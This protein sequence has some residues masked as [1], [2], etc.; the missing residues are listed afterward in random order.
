V[1][2]NVY[3]DVCSKLAHGGQSAICGWYSQRPSCDQKRHTIQCA[4]ISIRKA[5]DDQAQ[6]VLTCTRGVVSESETR[7]RPARSPPCTLMVPLLQPFSASSSGG[8]PLPFCVFCSAGTCSTCADINRRTRDGDRRSYA[9]SCVAEHARML[10]LRP[11]A[12]ADA[13]QRKKL[14]VMNQAYPTPAS[15]CCCCHTP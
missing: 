6:A 12:L 8:A 4:D 2:R 13:Y 7:G 10:K 15:Y 14:T 1:F 3:V 5:G 9:T 11:E